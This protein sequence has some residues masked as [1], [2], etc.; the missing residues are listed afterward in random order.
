VNPGIKQSQNEN[1]I[2]RHANKTLP[3]YQA[4]YSNISRNISIGL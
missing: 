2:G 3:T 1:K 4:A